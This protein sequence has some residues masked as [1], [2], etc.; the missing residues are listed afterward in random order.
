MKLTAKKR[1]MGWVPETVD[2]TMSD[3]PLN[4]DMAHRPGYPAGTREAM[5]LIE[6][7]GI[8]YNLPV[9]KQGQLLRDAG[10]K[11]SNQVLRAA[12]KAFRQKLELTLGT[13]QMLGRNQSGTESARHA[14]EIIRHGLAEGAENSPHAGKSIGQTES[15]TGWHDPAV[16]FGTRRY[17]VAAAAEDGKN[18]ATDT[19]S[20]SEQIAILG[21][22]Y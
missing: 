22:M 16:Q 13:E 19:T 14:P 20:I 17:I 12:I 6:Q 18:E 2:L 11:V 8:D 3:D 4:Y 1:R 15:G 7:C 21:E 5:T 9:A 10:H